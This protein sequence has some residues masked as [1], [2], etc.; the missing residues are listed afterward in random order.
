MPPVVIPQT[1]QVALTWGISTTPAAINLLHYLVPPGYVADQQAATDIGGAIAQHWAN[2][3]APSYRGGCSD[4]WSLRNIA[5]RDIRTANNPIF[6]FVPNPILAGTSS[7]GLLPPSNAMVVTLRTQKAGRSFRGRVYLGGWAEGAN[8]TN[9]LMTTAARLAG[10]AFVNSLLQ[11]ALPQ[12][13]LSLAVAS[14]TLG[15]SN[16]ATSAVVR[17]AVWDTQRRRGDATL[18]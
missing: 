10:E 2:V 4:Q 18:G 1:I 17:D 3:N 11:L 9:G 12:G 7:S 14:R 15:Q 8:Q 5:S 13:V 16:V 6:D